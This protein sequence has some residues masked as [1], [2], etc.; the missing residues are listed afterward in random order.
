[1]TGAS[2]FFGKILLLALLNVPVARATDGPIRRRQVLDVVRKTADWQLRNLPE[3]TTNSSGHV[4]VLAPT[5]WVRAAF[6]TGLLATHE[7]TGERRY[8]DTLRA[9]SQRSGW[10]LG[11]R[12][13]HA[14]D[15]CVGQTYLALYRLQPDPAKIT[16]L[17]T[18]FD[19]ILANPQPGPVAGWEKS[20]NWSWCDAL[21]MAPPAWA[22]LS[23]VTGDRRYL[24]FMTARWWETHDLLFD[25]TENLYYRDER[26]VW[27]N[28]T[29]P[30]ADPTMKTR[31]GGKI[32]WSRGNGWVL[33][34]L[35][36]VLDAMPKEYP[37]RPRFE[38]LFRDMARRI[39]ASQGADG[40]WPTNLMPDAEFP[41]PESSGSAFFCYGLAW[42]IRTGLLPEKQYG[43]ALRRAWQGLMKCVTPE[44]KLGYAQR[45]GHRPVAVSPDDSME[46]A[47]GALM[48]A[49]RELLRMKR[50]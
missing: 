4:E 28:G 6:Q 19:G 47:T 36:R 29:Q 22:A 39:V 20:K 30:P 21:F 34:G 1:M 26:F 25:K 46:Y 45:V 17:R 24:D 33:A 31:D 16:P 18:T 14:D 5:G 10:K 15:H 41:T 9:W 50:P 42:G 23:A 43:P 48:L 32:L 13:A 37:A 35:V 12:F 27:K 2:K 44:G 7:A 38:A 11:P 40:L 8:L 49:G 3:K